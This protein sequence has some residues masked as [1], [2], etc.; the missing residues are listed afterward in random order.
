ME[1]LE[2]NMSKEAIKASKSLM[3]LPPRV[4]MYI[5]YFRNVVSKDHPSSSISGL[6]SMTEHDREHFSK[7]ITSV[8][9]VLGMLTSGYLGEL[10]CPN[11]DNLDDPRPSMDTAKLIDSNQVVYI[12][13]DSLADK[14]IASALGSIIMADLAAVAGD[15]YSRNVQDGKRIFILIDEAAEVVNDPTIRIL[16]KGRGANFH[17][18]MFMQTINDLTA[19]MG[20][21]AKARMLLGNCNSIVCQRVRD[22]MT[23]KY[24]AE[25]MGKARVKESRQS[26]GTSLSSEKHL[27]SYSGSKSVSIVETE[28]DLFPHELLGAIPNFEYIG[29][30]SG[31]RLV[32]GRFPVMITEES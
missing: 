25:S 32:K 10:L 1:E 22:E 18:V 16:N 14:T 27:E 23:Q 21:D 29:I 9:P 19:R 13:L 31:G 6:I 4:R 30:L 3:A 15:R 24:V 11:P 20:S 7:M 2:K 17:C 12:G 26:M 8:I 28:V 5:Q